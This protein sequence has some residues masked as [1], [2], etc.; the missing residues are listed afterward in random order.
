MN[1][2]ASFIFRAFFHILKEIL[3]VDGVGLTIDF[4]GKNGDLYFK[5]DSEVTITNSVYNKK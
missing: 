3:F 4:V 1:L 2:F 5:T